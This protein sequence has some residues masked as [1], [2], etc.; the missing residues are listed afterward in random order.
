[1]LTGELVEVFSLELLKLAFGG[2]LADQSLYLL[3]ILL[4]ERG[5]RAAG[6][7]FD[8]NLYSLKDRSGR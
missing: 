4:S 1:M 3:N 6:S 5:H 8:F 2:P 7:H